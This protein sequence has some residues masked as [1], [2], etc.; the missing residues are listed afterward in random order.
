MSTVKV[1]VTT[2]HVHTVDV[3]ML[4]VRFPCMWGRFLHMCQTREASGY[5][6]EGYNPVVS[7]E[8]EFA[9]SMIEVA[10]DLFEP[11]EKFMQDIDSR[12]VPDQ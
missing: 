4:K 9:E 1:T 5:M 7:A 12:H 2:S 10:L 11:E 3:E 8:R 6:R